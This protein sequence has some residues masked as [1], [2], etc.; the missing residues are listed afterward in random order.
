MIFLFDST[1][2]LLIKYMFIF[3]I[4][5]REEQKGDQIEVGGIICSLYSYIKVQNLSA[6]FSFNGNHKRLERRMC[7]QNLSAF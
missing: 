2:V 1:C 5:L 6:S 4:T 3:L 7:T